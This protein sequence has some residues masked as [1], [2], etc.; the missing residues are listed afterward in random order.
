MRFYSYQTPEPPEN[1]SFRDPS[2]KIRFLCL[3]PSCNSR[4]IR[5]SDIYCKRYLNLFSNKIYSI[6]ILD[7]NLIFKLKLLIILCN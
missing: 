1:R 2:G 4:L 7:I 5:R 3:N 6:I